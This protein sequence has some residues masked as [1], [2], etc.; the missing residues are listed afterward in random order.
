VIPERLADMH[1]RYSALQMNEFEDIEEL[2]EFLNQLGEDPDLAEALWAAGGTSYA[3][4]AAASNDA[5]GPLGI[6]SISA[7]HLR[8]CAEGENCL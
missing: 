2:R 6:P 7:D 3:K 5:L 8:T 1:A 4:L